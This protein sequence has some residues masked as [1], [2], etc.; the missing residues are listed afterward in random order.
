MSFSFLLRYL[1]L[2]IEL[3]SFADMVVV[4]E[5]YVLVLLLLRVSFC[6]ALVAERYDA[7]LVID[8]LGNNLVMLF[9]T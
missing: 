1:L 9:K 2:S 5:D 6:P 4:V 8:L 7:S 3:V